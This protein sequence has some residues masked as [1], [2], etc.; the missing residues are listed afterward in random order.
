MPKSIKKPNLILGISSDAIQNYINFA[1]EK[2]LETMEIKEHGVSIIIKRHKEKDSYRIIPVQREEKPSQL[3]IDFQA[4]TKT[5][6]KTPEKE[7]A[8]DDTLHKIVSPLFGTF[9]R[10]PAPGAP[11][12][13]KNGD[14]VKSGQTLCIVE[15]MKVMNKISSNINGKIIKA[16]VENGQPVK[17]DQVLFFIEPS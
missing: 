17:K 4:D 2:K 1:E 7:P 10:S 5:S 16:P 15:A 3:E 14:A 13:V 11:P 12:F 9:Y 6:E 8:K